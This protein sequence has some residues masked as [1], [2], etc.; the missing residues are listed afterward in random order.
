MKKSIINK[1]IVISAA[2]ML[3]FSAAKVDAYADTVSGNDAGKEFED[4]SGDYEKIQMI[5]GEQRIL[6]PTS[7][8][9]SIYETADPDI[10]MIN[11]YG[12]M[13]AKKPGTV[14]VAKTENGMRTIYQVVVRESVDLI[15]FA[16]QSNM[17]G[18]GGDYQL[19]PRP[20][21]GT[22]YEYNFN[23]EEEKKLLTI[24][25]P[26]GNGTN[27]AYILN[28]RYVSG[29]G[30]LTSAFCIAYY[31]KAK[32]P[33][34]AVPAAWGGTSTNSWLKNNMLSST[35]SR[36]KKAKRFLKKNKV[37]IRHIYIVWYQGESDGQ[38]GYSGDTYIK[39]MKKIWKQFKRQGAEKIF[40]IKIAQ[41]INKPGI[42]NEIQSAQVKLC[43]KEKDFLM[44]STVASTMHENVGKWY[45]DV[46][47]INQGGLNVIG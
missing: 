32:T 25:E 23:E 42:M 13:T 6:A 39:N 33:I 37:K 27:R 19:A 41:Q 5:P 2:A 29:N 1:L 28:G 20:E 46:I 43:K 35:I 26:F 17:A 36:M 38:C 18:A 3:L 34:V 24:R 40:M 12:Q 14:K 47:H 21:A 15:I 4:A 45:F 30:T 16:G 8:P 7:S 44:A 11:G 31:N 22:A 9:G 10:V